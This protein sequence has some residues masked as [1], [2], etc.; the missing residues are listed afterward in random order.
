MFD[1][2]T[3]GHTAH[4]EAIVQ[5]LPHSDQHVKCDGLHSHGNS[6]LQMRYAERDCA[7]AQNLNT[8]C[9]VPCRKLASACVFEAVMADWNRSSNF[10]TPC[11][12]V[13]ILT[14]FRTYLICPKTYF[15]TPSAQFCTY[16]GENVFRVAEL[17]WSG[18][19]GRP[20]C[21]Y[22]DAKLPSKS[23]ENWGEDHEGFA[24]GLGLIEAGIIMSEDTACKN[25]RATEI[26]QGIMRVLSCY[27]AIL[28][29]K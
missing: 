3:L 28:K 7:C 22:S 29:V 16:D 6:V 21:W 11:T 23:L 9:F 17:L 27:E 10:D 20:S 2:C 8:C 25:Q 4:I 15:V 13:P 24:G 1:V 12:S 5:F 26:I 14:S 18:A 19:H